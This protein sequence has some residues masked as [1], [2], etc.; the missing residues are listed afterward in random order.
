MAVPTKYMSWYALSVVK[1]DL[2]KSEVVF[3]RSVMSFLFWLQPHLRVFFDGIGWMI[4]QPEFPF[5]FFGFLLLIVS[6][7]LV[8]F[9]VTMIQLSKE[10]K[11][12]EAELKVKKSDPEYAEYKRLFEKFGSYRE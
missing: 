6:I 3:R 1:Y 5:F 9:G 11:I 12:Q 7:S 4:S 10:I 8:C 2:L